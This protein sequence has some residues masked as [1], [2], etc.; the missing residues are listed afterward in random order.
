MKNKFATEYASNISNESIACGVKCTTNPIE[1]TNYSFEILVNN[2]D[3]T[4]NS[5]CKGINQVQQKRI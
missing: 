2:I 4:K 5:M 3:K 1:T